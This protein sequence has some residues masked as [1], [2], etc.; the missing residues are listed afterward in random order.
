M[1]FGG[2]CLI[3]GS[4]VFAGCPDLQSVA[5]KKSVDLGKNE[6]VSPFLRCP[7][8]TLYCDDINSSILRKEVR[9]DAF[10]AYRGPVE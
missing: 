2:D 3:N 6:S 8:A 4:G 10:A 7:D 5:C 9:S 1:Y